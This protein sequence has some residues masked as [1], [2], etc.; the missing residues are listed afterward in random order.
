MPRRGHGCARR[1]T[2]SARAATRAS[3]RPERTCRP[4]AGL[5]IS[6]ARPRCLPRAGRRCRRRCCGAGTIPRFAATGS[7]RSLRPRGQC[8]WLRAWR[9]IHGPGWPDSERDALRAELAAATRTECEF[10]DDARIRA[11]LRITANG[12]VVDG[13]LDGLLT[14][15]AEIGARLLH[16]LDTAAGPSRGA[17]C[18]PSG[19]SAAAELTNEAASV[20]AVR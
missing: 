20:G 16:L 7:S 2:K 1:S 6:S 8:S 15:R 11:G 17:N 10:V 14:D 9:V 5:P 19:G 4:G 12:N 18:S 3:L 13:T